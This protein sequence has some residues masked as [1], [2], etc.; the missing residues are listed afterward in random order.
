MQR[1]IT[2]ITKTEK[3]KSRSG[4]KITV[5]ILSAGV[6]SRIKS[7]EPRS[8]LKIGNKLLIEHQVNTINQCFEYP[9]IISVIGCHANKVVKK[10]RGIVRVV[11]NQLYDSSNSSESLRLAVNNTLNEN[12]LFMHGDLY[13]NENTLD[14]NYDK[15]F[16]IVDKTNQ[17]KDSEVGVTICD[18]KL[19][20]LSYGLPTKWAQIAYFTAKEFK[21]LKGIFQKYEHEDKKKLSFEI[22]NMVIEAGGNFECYE[23]QE[24]SIIEIDRIKDIK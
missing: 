4:R 5:A 7:Y 8:L 12:I 22:I 11:E 13:F 21:I 14:V 9:E 1:N 23:P 24:M 6:G 2:S 3:R 19:S 17:I 20:I 18:D 16:V 15:S 10:T